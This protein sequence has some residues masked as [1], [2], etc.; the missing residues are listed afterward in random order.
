MAGLLR[1]N[2]KIHRRDEKLNSAHC[3]SMPTLDVQLV[4]LSA[5]LAADSMK[6]M[7]HIIRLI[8]TEQL[9]S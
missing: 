1:S 6:W 9:A 3:N 4:Q 5:T 7:L 8:V 2:V